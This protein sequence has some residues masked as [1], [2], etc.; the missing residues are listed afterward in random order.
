MLPTGIPNDQDTRRS[1]AVWELLGDHLV[2]LVEA[3]RRLKALRKYQDWLWE[4][5]EKM[6]DIQAGLVAEALGRI[7]NES[8]T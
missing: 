2:E 3:R 7:L 8:D 1:D 5:D 4:A 6:V